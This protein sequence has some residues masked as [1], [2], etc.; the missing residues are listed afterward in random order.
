[1]PPTTN[2]KDL[3]KIDTETLRIIEGKQYRSFS[4]NLVSLN[5]TIDFAVSNTILY[6]P[7]DLI[8]AHKLLQNESSEIKNNGLPEI[9]ITDETTSAAGQRLSNI[10]DNVVILNFASAK[11]PGGGFL[12]GARAQ[13]EDLTRKSGLYACLKPQSAYYTANKKSRS[14]LYTDHL[15]YSPKVPFFRDDNLALVDEPYLLSVITSPAPNARE[16]LQKNPKS[17]PQI[18]EVLDRRAK[19]ILLAAKINNHRTLV[20]G[21]WGCGVFRNNPIHVSKVFLKHLE[22]DDFNGCFDTVVFA[23]YDLYPEKTLLKVF[24]ETYKGYAG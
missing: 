17:S 11:N 20:L 7:G 1:M 23:I 8:E 14:C 3:V 22:H 10:D 16:E 12:Y 5:D 24:K 18:F 19:D 4:G 9:Q 21:A 2:K 13:E 15:I 6:S